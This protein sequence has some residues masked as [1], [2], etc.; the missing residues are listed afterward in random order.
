[1]ITKEEVEMLPRMGEMS[2]E[3]LMKAIETAREVELPRFIISL[4][5]EQVGEETAYD[6]AKHFGS[7]EKIREAT[8]EELRAVY[9]IGE[10]TAKSLFEWFKDVSNRKFVDEL[11]KRVKIKSFGRPTSKSQLGGPVAKSNVEGWSFVFTGT[12]AKLERD[13]AK[14]MARD[15]GAEVSESVSKKTDYVVAGENAG[16]KLDKAR[17]LGVKIISEQEFLK[18]LGRDTSK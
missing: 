18:L 11:L 7:I 13:E 4:S 15:A 1:M 9:G 10:V 3:N 5:I 14:K 16:S 8:L 6:L 12:L 2:A 17:S